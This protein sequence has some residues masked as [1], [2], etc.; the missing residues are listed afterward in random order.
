M[1]INKITYLIY[2]RELRSDRK[3]FYYIRNNLMY[4]SLKNAECIRINGLYF[5]STKWPTIKFFRDFEWY[6]TGRFGFWPFKLLKNRIPHKGFIRRHR[7]SN[8]HARR[9]AFRGQE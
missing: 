9:R 4:L 2:S 5:P 7:Y 8:W 6:D 1:H 3:D